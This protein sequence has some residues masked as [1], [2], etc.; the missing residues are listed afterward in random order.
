[1][2]GV[3]QI[4]HNMLERLCCAVVGMVPCRRQAWGDSGKRGGGMHSAKYRR[5]KLSKLCAVE[6]K[7]MKN[8]NPETVQLAWRLEFQ[9]EFM[10]NF[11]QSRV[12]P[13][14]WD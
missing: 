7:E 5:M 8:T 13:Q 12:V 2:D 9:S 3:S 14:L 6:V 11:D 1:M 4:K 10:E